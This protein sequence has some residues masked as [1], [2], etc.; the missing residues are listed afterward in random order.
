VLEK[1]DDETKS[2]NQF[3]TSVMEQQPKEKTPLRG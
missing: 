3:E 1:S 2:L